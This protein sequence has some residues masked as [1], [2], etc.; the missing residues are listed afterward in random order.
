MEEGAFNGPKPIITNNPKDP[1]LKAYRDSSALFNFTQLQKKLE[2]SSDSYTPTLKESLF[3][4][5]KDVLTAQGRKDQNVLKSEVQKILKNNPDIKSGLYNMPSGLQR[6]T[7]SEYDKPGSYDIYSPNIKP[8]GAWMGLAPNNNY[9]NVQP[10]QEVIYK[11]P[12]KSLPKPTSRI[13]NVKKS[14]EAVNSAKAEIK[15]IY[16]EN[17]NDP[18]LRSYND[19]LNLYKAYAFQKENTN[20]MPSVKE[21]VTT[22]NK[23]RPELKMT[24]AKLIQEKEKNNGRIGQ[25]KPLRKNAFNYNDPN[26]GKG[27]DPL[28]SADTKVYNYLKSLKFNE[29]TRIGQYSSPDVV[30]KSIKPVGEYF[31]GIALS[32]VYKKPVQ[33]VIYKKPEPVKVEKPVK[34]EVTPQ[35]EVQTPAPVVETPTPKVESIKQPAKREVITTP[36]VRGKAKITKFEDTQTNKGYERLVQL[37]NGESVYFENIQDYNDW[38]KN[39]D[40]DWSRAQIKHNV[41]Y[42]VDKG[43]PSAISNRIEKAKQYKKQTTTEAKPTMKNG[44]LLNAYKKAKHGAQLYDPRTMEGH[45]V[46]MEDGGKKLKYIP[47]SQG[48]VYSDN[49]RVVTPDTTPTEKETQIA[50]SK[51][52]GSISQGK[53]KT[54]YEKAKDAT[55]FVERE[56]QRTGSASPISYVLDTVNPAAV[57]FSA[58]DL[59]KNTGSAIK[60]TAQ[61]NFREAGSDLLQAGVSAL[62]VLPAASEFKNIAKPL[63]KFARISPSQYKSV[64]QFA[65]NPLNKTGEYLT[66]QTP[67]KDAWKSNPL[68]FK[69]NPDAYYR[70]IGKEGYEDALKSGVVRPPQY[71]TIFD[72]GTQRYKKI[73]IPEF[74]DAYYN[75]KFPLDRKWYPNSISK[76]D[77]VRAIRTQKSGYKGPYMAEV[78]GDSHLFSDPNN[79]ASYGGPNLSGTVT[80]SK[81]HVPLTN[82]NLKFYKE[83]WLKGYKEVK[84]PEMKNGG[85]ADKTI[86]CSKCGWSWKASEGGLNP[87]SCHKCGGVAKMPNGG[88][89]VLEDYDKTM[90]PKKG[91]YLLPDINRPSYIDSEGGRRSEY[92]TGYNLLDEET[93][94]FKETLLPTVVNGK[95]LT[96][97]EA[98]QRYRDTG[99]HM[100][101]YETPHKS[102]YASRLR[103]A[104]YNMLEDPVRSQNIIFNPPEFK[105]GGKVEHS[106]DD[107]MV[108]GVASILRR[109]KDKKNRLQLAN[110]LSNQFN[111]EKVKYSLN[112]FLNKS[113]VKK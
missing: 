74:E 69:P 64:Q 103:T 111:R 5:P 32:P 88:S 110:Q 33:P 17:P 10:K 67:L 36:T 91:N 108:N 53:I 27:L 28:T 23:I 13:N 97:A 104:K 52:R 47:A 107:D 7:V 85:I 35:V 57:A 26:F 68:A 18:R 89:I 72:Q 58:A 113:K 16:T 6:P 41:P 37:D 102:E 81:E 79:V 76:T 56:K 9:S 61:G 82:P 59:V 99:L 101:K 48:R 24:P 75:A 95:Q 70:M 42:T 29:P 4:T 87:L 90:A 55:S 94:S 84:K 30:H 62:G 106:N 39:N 50:L 78:S 109:V 73:A 43:D 8:Q 86:T 51:R 40:L 12:V 31:D 100:G 93:G 77:P 15:P 46:G 105:K 38:E 92:K 2:Q 44:G 1:R 80:F 66:T 112:D 83:D 21:V 54:A 96:N 20:Y 49:A 3:G 63:S 60:N 71:M 14:I 25:S 22:L 34:E 45:I 98:I 11:E 65:N 19:S